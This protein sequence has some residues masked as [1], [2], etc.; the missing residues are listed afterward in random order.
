MSFGVIAHEYEVRRSPL[1]PVGPRA[2]PRAMETALVI[3]SFRAPP[4][5]AGDERPD[6][7]RPRDDGSCA[8][9]AGHA[10]GALTAYAVAGIRYAPLPRDPP[11]A[12]ASVPLR[13]ASRPPELRRSRWAATGR[14]S[15]PAVGADAG[16]DLERSGVEAWEHEQAGLSVVP[17]YLRPRRVPGRVPQ[18]AG[19]V[20]DGRHAPVEFVAADDFNG[21]AP[22]RRCPKWARGAAASL[23][24]WS[25]RASL[26]AGRS[27]AK[28]SR[29]RSPPP[30]GA[31]VVRTRSRA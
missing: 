31:P 10:G 11:L 16:D 17:R 24:C 15:A 20:E 23:S 8:G 9:G 25:G 22:C 28:R 1:A 29:R 14:R 7:V 4:P 2:M 26:S 6:R 30:E 27:R 13:V 19:V 21:L 3:S 18:D 5:A 12:G